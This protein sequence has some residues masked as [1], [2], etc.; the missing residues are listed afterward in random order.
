[1]GNWTFEIKAIENVPNVGNLLMQYTGPDSKIHVSVPYCGDVNDSDSSIFDDLDQENSSDL[2]IT[3]NSESSDS[4]DSVPDDTSNQS[5][6]LERSS[7][8]LIKQGNLLDYDCYTDTWPLIGLIWD[9][10]EHFGD[11][12]SVTFK[13]TDPGWN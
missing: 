10:D 5:D 3:D 4:G 8:V 2:I 9:L 11:Q 7:L 13:V 12:S 1:M 6:N